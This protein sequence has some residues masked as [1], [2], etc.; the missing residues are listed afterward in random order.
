MLLEEDAQKQR[1]VLNEVLFILL[2]ILIGLT[3]VG[4]QG[5]H[6]KV[7]SEWCVRAGE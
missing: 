6:L 2:A 1:Q 3:Y 4:A 5:K 7:V